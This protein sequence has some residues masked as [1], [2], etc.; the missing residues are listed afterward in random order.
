MDARGSVTRVAKALEFFRPDALGPFYLY[1]RPWRLDFAP[2]YL[3]EGLD[4]SDGHGG[5]RSVC[6]FDRE[7]VPIIC[8]GKDRVSIIR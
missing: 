7:G 4:N 3:V 5:Y 2:Y 8:A 6:R 1:P